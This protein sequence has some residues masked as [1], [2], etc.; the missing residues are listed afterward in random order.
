MLSGPA[1]ASAFCERQA[2]MTIRSR[3]EV[4]TFRHPFRIRGIDRLLP[5]GAYEVVTGGDDRGAIVRGVPP[6]RHHDQGAGGRLARVGDGG[7]LDPL[8]RSGRRATHRRERQ[9]YRVV[10]GSGER[11]WAIYE[12]L[13]RSSPVENRF[14]MTGT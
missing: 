5:A 3:R 9:P 7:G 13:A 4:V 1:P 2:R 11:H 14:S 6:H 8:G 10:R 12:L